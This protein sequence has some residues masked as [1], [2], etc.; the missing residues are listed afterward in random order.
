MT[1][2]NR[3]L[4]GLLG[5]VGGIL[6]GLLGVW[7][8][9]WAARQGFYALLLPGGGVGIGASLASQ[10]PSQSRGLACGAV[11]LVLGVI[12]EW[13]V[14]PFTDDGSLGYFLGHLHLL[15]PM[16]WL[17]I[18]VGAGLAYWIGRDAGFLRNS[19]RLQ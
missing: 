7:L 18:A 15:R 14:F 10:R 19:R 3:I 8:V 11:G 1:E 16:T 12:A 9:D 13:W 4:D 2:R 17:L 6:G 5:A